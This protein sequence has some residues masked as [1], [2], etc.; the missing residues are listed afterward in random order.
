MDGFRAGFGADDGFVARNE[1]VLALQADHQRRAV[2][3]FFDGGEVVAVAENGG[4]KT[5]IQRGDEF[6][7]HK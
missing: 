6:E 1:A 2:T 5:R 3:G 4:L 7:V